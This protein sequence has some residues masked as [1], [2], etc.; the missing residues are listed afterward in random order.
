MVSGDKCCDAFGLHATGGGRGWPS[1]GAGCGV[2]AR[3]RRV[4]RNHRAP[5]RGEARASVRAG[6]RAEIISQYRAT[7]ILD[8]PGWPG[9]VRRF[10]V[11]FVETFIRLMG[12]GLCG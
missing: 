8:Y 10:R 7:R 2:A 12:G 6:V 4:T 11:S 1:P 3:G 9:G 5:G